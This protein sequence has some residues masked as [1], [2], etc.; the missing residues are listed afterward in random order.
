MSTFFPRRAAAAHAA[1]AALAAC[2]F[3]AAPSAFAQ[4]FD[5][6]RLYGAAPGKDGGTAGLAV[7]AGHQYR[8]SDERR[9]Q[10]FP[11]LD[12]QWRSG[13]FAG[14]TNG[15]GIN[16]SSSPQQQYGVRLTADLGRKESR[17]GALRGMGNVGAKAEAGAFYNLFLSESVFVSSSLR[18][19]SGDGG[20]GVV[21]D[22]GAGLSTTL[23]PQWRLG[24]GVAL[25]L[26]NASHMQSYFGVTAAQ[27]ARSGYRAT[28]AGAGLR[29][30]RANVA[31]T[32]V[33]DMQQSVTLAVSA[34]RLM[35]DAAS[36]PITRQRNSVGG[37]LAY[38]WRF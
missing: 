33:I 21:L 16:L 14:V 24:T 9:A 20:K 6:V 27:A 22:L 15:V 31:L 19:G 26:A 12:Y 2:L 10:L 29:D 23:A 7:V 32:H 17:S 36:S 25:S 8:G 3:A 13:W 4:A 38:A 30:V 5:A 37:V 18:A 1:R 28:D 34:N 11:A 35:G